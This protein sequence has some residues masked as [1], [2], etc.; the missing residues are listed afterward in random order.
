MADPQ[1]EVVKS[2]VI[3][4]ASLQE[5]V[6]HFNRSVEEAARVEFTPYQ[7]IMKGLRMSRFSAH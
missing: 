7:R 2:V 1:I 5:F 4:K 6:P 3:K